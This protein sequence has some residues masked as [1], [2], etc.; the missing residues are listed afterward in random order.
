MFLFPF[1]IRE[2]LVNLIVINTFVDPSVRL[3]KMV[4]TKKHFFSPVI[5][6]ATNIQQIKHTQINDILDLPKADFNKRL[7]TLYSSIILHFGESNLII[8]TC[9]IIYAPICSFFCPLL[10]NWEIFFDLY[11]ANFNLGAFFDFFRATVS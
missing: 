6:D 7:A 8:I 1:P 11:E 5:I 10:T 3:E 9:F 4:N 2:I